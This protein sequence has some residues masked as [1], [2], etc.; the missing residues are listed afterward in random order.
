VLDGIGEPGLEE[1]ASKLSGVVLDTTNNRMEMQAIIEAISS[2][3]E[4]SRLRIFSDSGYVVT[5]FTHPS[6]LKKWMYNGWKTSN[7]NPV[8]NKDLWEKLIELNNRY[9]IQFV[10]IK[11]H[12][13]NTNRVHN[14]F[15]HI[16][17]MMCTRERD[18]HNA[19]IRG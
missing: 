10:L 17:D 19:N 2:Q 5:G 13:K 11:G 18:T 9:N 3:P 7:N 12:N 6:Y 15:N 4:G 16:V 14:H 1:S 8:G